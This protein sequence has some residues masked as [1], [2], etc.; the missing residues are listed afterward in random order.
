ML[1]TQENGGKQMDR[2]AQAGTHSTMSSY[3]AI[4][5]TCHKRRVARAPTAAMSPPTPHVKHAMCCDAVRPSCNNGCFL[6]LAALL[7]PSSPLNASARIS[8]HDS[9]PPD[10]VW[11]YAAAAARTPAAATIPTMNYAFSP[12]RQQCLRGAHPHMF[13]H[14]NRA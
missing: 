3:V 14:V 13:V 9:P 7:P 5:T 6:C 10:M 11:L 8:S 1:C 4:G 12:S 2:G